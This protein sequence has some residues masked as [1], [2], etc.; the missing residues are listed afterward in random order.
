MKLDNR[1]F[2]YFRR[3]ICVKQAVCTTF[4]VPKWIAFS[5]L[6]GQSFIPGVEQH[7]QGVKDLISSINENQLSSVIKISRSWLYSDGKC[8]RSFDLERW[9]RGLVQIRLHLC[10]LSL[11]YVHMPLNSSFNLQWN[12]P[13]ERLHCSCFLDC[14]SWLCVQMSFPSLFLDRHTIS[15]VEG[16][17]VFRPW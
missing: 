3:E 7:L 4:Q 13:W 16:Y 8:V 15:R 17:I 2:Y 11:D 1:I 12:F 14:A 5:L 9:G 10:Y 6:N